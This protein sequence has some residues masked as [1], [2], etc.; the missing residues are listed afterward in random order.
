MTSRGPVLEV[1]GGRELRAALKGIENGLAD[2]KATHG[3]IAAMVAPVGRRGAPHR[4][5]ALSASV[6]GSGTASAAIVR[7]GGARLPYAGPIHW[8][9]PARNIGAQPFLTDAGKSTEPAWVAMYEHD[10]QGLID[11]EVV[12]KAKH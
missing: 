3:K 9:W 2:L 8:G 1:E 4:T 11:S 12:S 5:G 7:A 6:R 10:V